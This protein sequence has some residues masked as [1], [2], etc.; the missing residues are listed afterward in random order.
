MLSCFIVILDTLS[1][2]S[3]D[4]L[5][6]QLQSALT[7]EF[8]NIEAVDDMYIVTACRQVLIRL[9][10]GYRIITFACVRFD[11]LK[12]QMLLTNDT[13]VQHFKNIIE[14]RLRE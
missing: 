14:S 6:Y 2:D 7:S 10:K 3:F 5:H 8:I 1:C 11:Q 9:I 12:F 13:P 4:M